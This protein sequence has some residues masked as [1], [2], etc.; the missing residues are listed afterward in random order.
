MSTCRSEFIRTVV[1]RGYLH[2]CTDIEALDAK[3][4]AGIVPAYIGFDCTADSLH[5]GSLIQ[6]MLL[7]RLQQAGHKPV[8]LMGG[9]TT[10]IGDPSGRDE[11]R[12]LLTDEKIAENMAGI[13][14]VFA[15]YLTFGDGPTD[16]VMVNNADWLNGLQYI[17]F[18]RDYGRHFSINRMLSF[19]SVKL[20]LEREHSLSFLEF[21][22]MIL[23]A[24]D[25]LE[26]NRS[27]GVGLQMGGS[28]Q[29]GN[30]VNGVELTRRCDAKE[31]FGLTSPLLTT[32]SGAKMGKTASG[33][34]WLNAERLSAY[35]YWQFWRNTEDADVGKFLRLFTELPLDEIARLEGLQGAEINDAKKVLADEV[36]RLC[37]GTEAA[38]A[39]RR[40]AEETFEKGGAGGDLPTVE[41]P[42]AELEAG[43][44]LVDLLVRLEMTASKGEARRL[45][46]QGGA[47]VN[48]AAVTDEAHT[49]TLAA[50][51]GDHIKLSAGKKKH[52][53]VKPA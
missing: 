22:Y 3:M 49:V 38:E 46:K 16:A 5:V 27:R 53:L 52:A 33:A 24:Y 51:D 28:D 9:G 2:Q 12:Q 26:L 48:D 21:N 39:A 23:Q 25:F 20:R 7:R 29:W 43:V 30:I 10:R 42:R 40:T 8:V 32:A 19:D 17:D 44:A 18:L 31:V 13:K 15:K 41:V 6:I 1:E 11:A 37:H 45:I 50:L 35:D 14:K 47:R 36:T 34:V 4:Q